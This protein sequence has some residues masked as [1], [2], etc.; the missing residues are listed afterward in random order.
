M[1]T[2]LGQQSLLQARLLVPRYQSALTLIQG[3]GQGVCS[4]GSSCL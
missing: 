1:R 4:S 3:Q 2:E